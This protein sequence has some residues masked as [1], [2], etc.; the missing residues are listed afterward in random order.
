MLPTSTFDI[1]IKMNMMGS[2]S[3]LGDSLHR[4]TDPEEGESVL[5]TLAE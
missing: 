3:D 1:L 5:E 4:D 2:K